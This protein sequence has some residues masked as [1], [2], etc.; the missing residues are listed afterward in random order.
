MAVR[1]RAAARGQQ[2]LTPADDG[3]PHEAFQGLHDPPLA[4]F[5]R[6]RLPGPDEL[7]RG[8]RRHPRGRILRAP[9]RPSPGGGPGAGGLL[10]RQRSRARHRRRRPLRRPGRR[11]PLARRA[12]LRRGRALPGRAHGPEG[13]ARGLRGARERAPARHATPPGLLRPP[14]PHRGRPRPRRDRRRG[15]LG[16]RGAPHGRV[17]Q[18]PGPGGARPPRSGGAT[19]LSRLPPPAQARRGGARGGRPR[20]PAGA[21]AAAASTPTTSCACPVRRRPR[22]IPAGCGRRSRRPRP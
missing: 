15:P 10:D 5:L 19:R 12:R 17:R 18:R 13:P 6:G 1:R 16:E 4:L 14:Q 7:A 3:W 2:V 9:P 20:R 11:R 8:R 21:R 22:A